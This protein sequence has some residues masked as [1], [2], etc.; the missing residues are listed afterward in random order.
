MAGGAALP[1]PGARQGHSSHDPEARGGHRHDGRREQ[2]RIAEARHRSLAFAGGQREA[3]DVD[4]LERERQRDAVCQEP[5]RPGRRVAARA[6]GSSRHCLAASP[7]RQDET[8]RDESDHTVER[9][10]PGH[11]LDAV[12]PDP[13]GDQRHPGDAAGRKAHGGG[14]VVVEGRERARGQPGEHVARSGR[15]H[16]WER[17]G[18]GRAG[19]LRSLAGQDVR[20]TSRRDGRR[21]HQHRGDEQEDEPGPDGFGAEPAVGT[22]PGERGQHRDSDRV[23]HQDDDDEDAVRGEEPVRLGREPQL[24]GDDHPDDRGQPRLHRQGESRDRAR[25]EGPVTRRGGTL[26][27]RRRSLRTAS[28]TTVASSET[29]SR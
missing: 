16:P 5:Q 17:G 6:E 18:G 9:H 19:E 22:R 26:A 12:L 3:D 25:G 4:R 11:G 10:S 8:G 2:V 13:E 14:R 28:A 20:D 24:A 15:D 23:G 21:D 27:H 7:P 29:A 1:E